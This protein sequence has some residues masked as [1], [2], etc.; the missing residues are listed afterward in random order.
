MD[1]YAN[2]SVQISN[3]EN[4]NL[5]D[6]IQRNSLSTGYKEEITV[7]NEELDYITKYR[8]NP[9]IYIGKTE[10]AQEGRNGIQAITTKK[11]FDENGKLIKEEQISVVV[12][13]ASIN[14]VIDIGT[15]KKEAPKPAVSVGSTSGKLDFNMALNKPSGF[16]LEDFTKALTD[17]RDKRK[18]FQDNAKYF[19]YAEKQYNINGIFVAAIGIHESAWGT[20]RIAKDKHNLFGYGAYD[21]SP[22]YSAYNF[23]TYAES[24]DLVSRMLVKH[25]I[26]PKGTIIYSGEKAKAKYYNGN[27]LSAVNK[28][29]AT[30]KNWAKDVYTHMK[31]LYNKIGK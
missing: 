17:S 9:K 10:V 27:T 12:V 26:N 18:V 20:S 15:K 29:Y 3:A 31:Y 1:T 8:N 25:Y 22:Y 28:C 2:K 13:K 30:S 21:S 11:T 4:V 5:D 23:E 7:V 6:I 14:K 16:S 19:Y 24:I